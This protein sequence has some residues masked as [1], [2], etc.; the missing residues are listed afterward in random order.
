[1]QEY[2]HETLKKGI[3]P[4]R[5]LNMYAMTI[6]FSVILPCRKRRWLTASLSP[7]S[8]SP[9]SGTGQHFCTAALQTVGFGL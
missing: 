6:A 4:S 8:S 2:S 7:V 1:M 3:F 9:A 5:F